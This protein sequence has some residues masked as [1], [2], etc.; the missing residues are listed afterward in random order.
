MV[1]RAVVWGAVV[2]GVEGLKDVAARVPGLFIHVRRLCPISPYSLD[3]YA[4]IWHLR[5][6]LRAAGRES[7]HLSPFFVRGDGM[8][9][10]PCLAGVP[11]SIDGGP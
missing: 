9:A 3:D 8:Q 7:I 5:G 11:P 6:P 10:F 2:R 4:M 1:L